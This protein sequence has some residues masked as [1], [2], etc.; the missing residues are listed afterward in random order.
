MKHPAETESIATQR[1]ASQAARSHAENVAHVLG[2]ITWETLDPVAAAL[3]ETREAGRVIHAFGNGA[4]AA[5]ASQLAL[6]LGWGQHGVL[7]RPFAVHV[8][9]EGPVLGTAIGNDVGFERL[10][11]DPISIHARAGDAVLAISG[12][13]KS[14]NIVRAVEIANERGC[15]TIAFTGFDGGPLAKVAS[16]GFHVPSSD[17]AVIEE[18]HHLALDALAEFLVR[19]AKT[20]EDSQKGISK[21]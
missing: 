5:L 3:W 20:V 17:Y 6:H 8:H 14:P 11:A 9:G 13:G 10:F 1:Y 12:S 19:A 21:T 4:S 15:R 7:C 18:L 16:V 2:R